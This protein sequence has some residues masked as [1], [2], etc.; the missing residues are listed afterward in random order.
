MDEIHGVLVDGDMSRTERSDSSGG[1][2]HA[3]E[4]NTNLAVVLESSGNGERSGKAATERV[5]QH[6]HLLTGILGEDIIDIIA[7]KVD[8]ADEA[9]Q[10]KIVLIL[11]HNTISFAT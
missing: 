1:S 4:V 5:N 10:V 2:I 6:V 7:V 3:D 11:R 8:T 9:F